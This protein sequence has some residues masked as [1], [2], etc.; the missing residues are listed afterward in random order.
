[1]TYTPVYPSAH[2]G[3]PLSKAEEAREVYVVSDLFAC[4]SYARITRRS[5]DAF[6]SKGGVE[7]MGHVL[8]MKMRVR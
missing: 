8:K 3:F 1:M 6:L 5:Y 4:I 7:C 2:P